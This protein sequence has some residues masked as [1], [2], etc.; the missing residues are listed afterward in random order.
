M[1]GGDFKI[2][3][4]GATRKTVDFEILLAHMVTRVL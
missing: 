1:I 2:D 3:M 4:K